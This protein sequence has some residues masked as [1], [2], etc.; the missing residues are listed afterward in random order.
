MNSQEVELAQAILEALDEHNTYINSD[1]ALRQLLRKRGMHQFPNTKLLNHL[2][3]E[4]LL[5]VEHPGP[6]RPETL[7]R[8]TAHG[9]HVRHT[10]LGRYLALKRTAP[11][12]DAQAKAATVRA[13]RWAKWALIVSIIALLLSLLA[14]IR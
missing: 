3:E 2:Q 11:L 12:L 1:H 13:E 4:G 14:H 8:L 9:S 7:F 5:K 10:G 6:N